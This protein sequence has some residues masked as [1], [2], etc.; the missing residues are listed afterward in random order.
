MIALR[1][2]QGNAQ[3][4]LELKNKMTEGIGAQPLLHEP[5]ITLKIE[6]KPIHFLVD[7]RAQHSILK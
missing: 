7:T 3:K 1:K 4:L 2:T 6:G 5:W